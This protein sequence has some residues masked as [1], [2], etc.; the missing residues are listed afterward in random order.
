MQKSLALKAATAV[1]QLLSGA[2]GSL[3]SI[4]CVSG[5]PSASSNSLA[6]N[7]GNTVGGSGLTVGRRTKANVQDRHEQEDER[8]TRKRGGLHGVF[9]DLRGRRSDQAV[10]WWS[11]RQL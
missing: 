3:T 8:S 10:G 9:P 11:R 1:I 2:C 5:N 7:V 4:A 6:L